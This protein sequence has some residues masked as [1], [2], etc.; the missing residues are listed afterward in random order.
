MERGVWREMDGER[1]MKRVGC[2]GYEMEREMD[3]EWW[4][5]RDGWKE[6]DGE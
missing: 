1:W 5:E 2:K 3:E 6:F 4:M